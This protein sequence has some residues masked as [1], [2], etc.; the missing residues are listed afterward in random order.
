MV[1]SWARKKKKR[2]RRNKSRLECRLDVIR[3]QRRWRYTTQHSLGLRGSV[4]YTKSK[5][6]LA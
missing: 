4:W 3:G 6:T 2:E 5:E 1:R